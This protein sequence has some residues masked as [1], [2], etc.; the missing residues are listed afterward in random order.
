[1]RAFFS[2]KEDYLIV[3]G[4]IIFRASRYEYIVCCEE[5]VLIYEEQDG[6]VAFTGIDQKI[7]PRASV[8]TS[9]YN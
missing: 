1:M 2:R 4:H 5:P 7:E 3:A 9:F 6:F 8:E